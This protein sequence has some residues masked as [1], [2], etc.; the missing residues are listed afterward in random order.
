MPRIWAEVPAAQ[1]MTEAKLRARRGAT[2]PAW[3]TRHLRYLEH[4]ICHAACLWFGEGDL[5]FPC[6]LP[7]RYGAH[8]CWRHD[9]A[10]HEVSA[11]AMARWRTSAKRIANHTRTPV[12]VQ[13]VTLL[14]AA[15]MLRAVG[16]D[17][18]GLDTSPR[19]T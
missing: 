11:R 15:L 6:M 16:F 10:Y 5:Y 8:F 18:W 17:K 19:E 3:L 4:P 2:D 14:E 7:T 9:P 12:T 13:R 1:R